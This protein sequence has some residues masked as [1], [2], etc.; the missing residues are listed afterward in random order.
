[1]YI[2]CEMC[3]V[4]CAVATSACSV[5]GASLT[6]HLADAVT[7]MKPAHEDAVSTTPH[8]SQN[9]PHVVNL[10]IHTSVF[11]T[12]H[13]SKEFY[14]FSK[15]C[16]TASGVDCYHPHL[17]KLCCKRERGHIQNIQCRLTSKCGQ[18]VMRVI[19]KLE[20]VNLN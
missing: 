9:Y 1:M 6:L 10:V 14:L 16:I 2:Y 12:S 7:V 11:S 8:I 3:I 18:N 20:T 5:P 13:I 17:L 19:Q 15:S 4:W